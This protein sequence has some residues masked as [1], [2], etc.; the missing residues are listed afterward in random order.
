MYQIMLSQELR[1]PTRS[2]AQAMDWSLVLI[3]QGI[4]STIDHTGD[5]AGWGLLVASENYQNAVAAIRQYTI[6]NRGWPWQREIFYP[7]LMFDWGSLAWV[8][9]LLLFFALDVQFNLRTRG[10]MESAT[11]GHGQWWRL[12]TAMWLHGDISHLAAN[13]TIGIVLLGLT[14]ARFGTGAGLLAA[15]LAG[16]GGNVLVFL[17]LPTRGPSLGA[18]GMVMGCLGLLAAESLSL[19]RK[20][21]LSPNYVLAGIAGGVMLFA[22]LGLSPGTDVL[23]HLGGFLTGLALGG[24][25]ASFPF[26]AKST[27]ANLACGCLFACLAILPWWLAL[28]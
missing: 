11:V 14:M 21:S 18:S 25:L 17:L 5:D 24:L 7:G 12:F 28:R 22:L 10:V 27:P 23:A 4:D 19:R 6:E 16:A 8:T 2:R 20:K 9:L 3:S 1:I 13:A 26:S 15:Y